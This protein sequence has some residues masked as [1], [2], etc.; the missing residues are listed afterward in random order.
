MAN[1]DPNDSGMPLGAVV[2]SEESR[3]NS[4][5]QGQGHSKHRALSQSSTDEANSSVA[6]ESDRRQLRKEYRD[7]LDNVLV[8]DEEADQKTKDEVIKMAM[9]KVKLPKAT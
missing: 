5:G 3:L 9:N 8:Q 4:R 2:P 6:S 7:L 1:R